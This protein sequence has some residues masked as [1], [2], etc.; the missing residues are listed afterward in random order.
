MLRSKPG[1]PALLALHVL[2]LSKT[3]FQTYP[4]AEM[5]HNSQ[6]R[7]AAI[8]LVCIILCATCGCKAF[9]RW[10]FTKSV[11]HLR[12]NLVGSSPGPT[13]GFTLPVTPRQTKSISGDEHPSK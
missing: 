11:D 2:F 8:C 7:G 12:H 4:E 9:G 6:L 5:R 1:F 3:A 13:N 10:A